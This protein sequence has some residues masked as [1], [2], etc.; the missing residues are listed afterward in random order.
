[1]KSTLKKDKDIFIEQSQYFDF[2]S[3]ADG[4]GKG[5]SSLHIDQIV[6]E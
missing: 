1:M 4:R 6:Q 2:R 3:P 5:I